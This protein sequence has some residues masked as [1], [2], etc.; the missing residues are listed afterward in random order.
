MDRFAVREKYHPQVTVLRLRNL[1][2]PLDAAISLHFPLDRGANRSFDP[3]V[4]DGR[5]IRAGAQGVKVAGGPHLAT[6]PEPSVTSRCGLTFALSGRAP[7]LRA[8]A[9]ERV[10]RLHVHKTPIADERVR[11]VPELELKPHRD[12]WLRTQYRK[13]LH[14]DQRQP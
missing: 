9:L 7:H 13:A 1:R 4:S 10:V 5:P 8:S 2:P 12:E 11:V 14:W 3:L 6:V